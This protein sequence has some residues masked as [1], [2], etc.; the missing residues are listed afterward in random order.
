VSSDGDIA[1]NVELVRRGDL[2]ELIRHVDHLG[3]AGDWA[4]LADLHHRCRAA[5]DT[6]R[7]LWPAASLAQY[8]LALLGSA[9]WAAEAVTMGEATFAPGPLTEVAAST[10]TW[11]ELAA[12][13]PRGAEAVLC[14][15]ERAVRRDPDAAALAEPPGPPLF[16]V[17]LAL[18]SWEPAYQLATYRSNR[19]EAPAPALPTPSTVRLPSTAPDLFVDPAGLDALRDLARA[20]T[21]TSAGSSAAAAVAGSAAGALVVLGCREVRVAEVDAATALSVMAW[22]AASGG[23]HGRRRGAAVGRADTWWAL[24]ALGGL[25]DEWPVAADELGDVAGELRWYVWDEGAPVTG[26]AL[27]LAVEDPAERLAWA[28]SAS[29]RSELP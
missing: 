27:R 28:V 6:G 19:V 18:A 26:W 22:T 5:F 8:R 20:W 2:D 14:A 12:H 1:A 3:D 23:A 24:A 21:V 29:D 15:Q 13:L 9:E 10:H 7:Q 25:T 4:G 11:G 17:P 16:D